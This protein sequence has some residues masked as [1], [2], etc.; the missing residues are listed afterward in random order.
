MTSV[1]KNVKMLQPYVAGGSV[2][3]H[4]FCVTLSGIE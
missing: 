3:W 2:R 1:T 4:G